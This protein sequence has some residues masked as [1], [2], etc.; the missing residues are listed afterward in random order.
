MKCYEGEKG[1]HVS[2]SS[3]ILRSTVA[4]RKHPIDLP[5][6][7]DRS[8]ADATVLC[9]KRDVFSEVIKTPDGPRVLVKTVPLLG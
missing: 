4:R 8:V 5:T 1:R 2:Y 9:V 7:V 3:Q 6:R